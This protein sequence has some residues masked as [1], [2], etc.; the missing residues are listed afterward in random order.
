MQDTWKGWRGRRLD[1]VQVVIQGGLEDPLDKE[2]EL[3]DQMDSLPYL[4]RFQYENTCT[5]ICSL[6]DPVIETF[7]NCEHLAALPAAC[8]LAPLV[9]LEPSARASAGVQ[10]T[11]R[12]A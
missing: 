9:I 2:E 8:S 5:Y 3:Q 12:T 6:L 10:G 1:S 7:S 11:H 4:C